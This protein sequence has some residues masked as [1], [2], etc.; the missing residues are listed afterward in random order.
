M[1]YGPAKLLIAPRELLFYTL[2]RNRI[3]RYA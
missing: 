1:K 2:D 3:A